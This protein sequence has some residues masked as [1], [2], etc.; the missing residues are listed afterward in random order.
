MSIFAN[1]NFAGHEQVVFCHD[2]ATGLKA[3]IAIHNTTL[4]P[5]LGGT[6][7]WDYASEDDALTDVLRLSK[8]MTYKAAAANLNLG[9]GKAVIIGKPENVKQ[10]APARCYGKFVESLNGRYITAE[11]VNTDTKF[12]EWIHEE[13]D[14][15]VGLPKHLGGIGDPSPATAHGVFMGILAT[16]KEATGSDNIS[17]KKVAVQGVGHVG[18]YLCQ[19]LAKH[20][21]K[22]FISDIN[23]ANLERVAKETGATVVNNDEIHA[24]DVDVYAPCALGAILNE[25]TIPVLKCKVI[26]GAANNQLRVEKEHSLALQKAGIIYAPDYV[27]NGGGLINVDAEI[28]GLDQEYVQSKV[29]GIYDTLLT[30]YKS[31]KEH[32]ITTIEAANKFAED[33][34]HKIHQTKGMYLSRGCC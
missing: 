14:H 13:T 20:G 24:L 25:K 19:E 33:R 32:N 5:A 7:L 9:G 6:R 2:K 23:K 34:I 27:I 18:S 31:A 4:G 15:V 3:I 10:E 1:E 11:D 30:I 8:G 28:T 26:A 17:G 16:V 22:L 12:M 29:E 21:A